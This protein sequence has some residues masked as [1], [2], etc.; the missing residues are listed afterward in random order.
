LNPNGTPSS[1]L[2]Q[3]RAVPRKVDEG[4]LAFRNYNRLENRHH[5]ELAYEL[6]TDDRYLPLTNKLLA[7]ALQRWD[8][9][10]WERQW[11]WRDQRL[12]E[13]LFRG[14]AGLWAWIPPPAS[15]PLAQVAPTTEETA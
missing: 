11:R 3:A 12:H 14:L 9:N 13:A 10:T 1:D 2:F 15:Q 6:E 8:P 7:K 4:L 5:L